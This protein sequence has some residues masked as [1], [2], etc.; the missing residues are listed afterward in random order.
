MLHQ[1]TVGETLSMLYHIIIGEIL[2][3]LH[4]IIIRESYQYYVTLIS[5]ILL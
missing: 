5:A 2:S 3:V 4:Q 1:I